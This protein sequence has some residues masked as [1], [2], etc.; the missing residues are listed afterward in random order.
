MTN[1][2]Q[3]GRTSRFSL[4]L[5]FVSVVAL[6]G[7]QS[8][9][10]DVREDVAAGKS[11]LKEGDEAA[12]R[13]DTTEAVIRYKRAFEKLLPGLRKLSFKNEV[14]RDV[15][16]REDMQALLLKEIDADMTPQEFRANELGMKALGLLPLEFNL[17]EVMVKVYSEEIAAFYDTKTK[18]MHLIKESEEKM[19]KPPSFLERLMGKTG[20]FDKDENKTVIAHEL[21]H[22]LADQ[23]FD[24]DAMQKRV[25]NND[26]RD[27]ALSALI[28]GEATLAMIGAQMQ[29]W[30]GTV[31]RDIPADNLDRIFGF[32]IPLMPMAGGKSLR[33][34][35]VILS[36]SMIFPYLRGMVF[37]ARL[38]NDGG[39]DALNEAYKNPPLSTEQILHPEKYK[40]KP[41]YPTEIDL[42]KLDPGPGW[43]EAGRNVVG[44]MQLGVMLR[45][46]GGKSAAAGWDGDHYAVFEGEAGR[47]GLVWLTT[48]DTE[49]DASEFLTAYS[50]FQTSKMGDDAKNLAAR[51]DLVRRVSNDRVYHVERRG[52][53]VLVVEGLSAE[54]TDSLIKSAFAAKKTEL[55]RA[56]PETPK[57]AASP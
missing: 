22:A 24:I 11:L 14:K 4:L 27:L 5:T 41:D 40:A 34:A 12:D 13:G 35:P 3:R 51:N 49:K 37:C 23:N 21:T 8:F 56:S 43:K 7:V 18:T 19:K 38:T 25:K 29:D 53:D 48:W 15:T 39:W 28:E 46:Q 52:S 55:T 2:Q 33:E 57:P 26:D 47:L 17:K 9:A 32:L 6:V 42:G 1:Q 16:A 31:I 10:A 50:K 36:E 44:E 30:D 54:P 45:R 20:G